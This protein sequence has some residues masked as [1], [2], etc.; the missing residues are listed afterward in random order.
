MHLISLDFD[1]KDTNWPIHSTFFAVVCFLMVA[2]NI[3][4]VYDT[5]WMA[6][7]EETDRDHFQGSTVL[8][9]SI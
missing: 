3:Q 8:K 4:A 7:N 1:N 6:G 9:L 2:E 5:K